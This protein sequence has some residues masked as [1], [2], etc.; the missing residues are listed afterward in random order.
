MHH[1]FQQNDVHLSCGDF[2]GVLRY[3]RKGDFVYMDPPYWSPHA[4]I[5]YGSN[6]FTYDDQL[7]VSTVFKTL[8]R[9][10]CH[11]MLSNSN[12]PDIRKLYKGFTIRKIAVH[13]SAHQT[14]ATKID[15]EIIVTN[16]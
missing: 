10:G 1:L 7:R 12:S 15:H 9:R 11:V 4:P 14:T 16:Y 2:A 8:A 5:H 6:A 13:R 3:A